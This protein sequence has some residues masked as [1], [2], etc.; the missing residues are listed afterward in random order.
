M[1]SLDAG[2]TERYDRM[3]NGT[4]AVDLEDLPLDRLVPLLKKLVGEMKQ[5]RSETHAGQPDRWNKRPDGLSKQIVRGF[6]AFVNM[7]NHV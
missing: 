6:L 7:A 1:V 4:D 5:Q 3:E 2:F